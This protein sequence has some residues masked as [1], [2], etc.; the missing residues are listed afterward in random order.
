LATNTFEEGDVESVPSFDPPEDATT[1]SEFP[2]ATL[3]QPIRGFGKVWREN[4]QLREQLG[5]AL[6][7]EV[8]HSEPREYIAGG[9]VDQDDNYVPGP[10]EYR[11]RSF[12]SKV[13][14]FLEAELDMSCPSGTWRSRPVTD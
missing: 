2:N 13:F 8:E 3:Q 1:A 10:G 9:I 6:A 11:L 7:S 5:Y 14:T 4:D 12:Y